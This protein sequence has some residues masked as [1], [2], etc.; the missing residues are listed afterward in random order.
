MNDATLSGDIVTVA[1][2]ELELFE[3]GSEFAQEARDKVKPFAQ[4]AARHVR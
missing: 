2:I 4:A 1:G 3:R